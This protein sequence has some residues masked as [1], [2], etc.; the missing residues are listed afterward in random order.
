M[1]IR[2]RPTHKEKQQETAVSRQLSHEW[3]RLF[4]SE[5]GILYHKPGTRN[6]IV[7]PRKYHKR[8][9]EELHENMGHLGA[10]R[11]VELAR[12]GFYWPFMRADITHY[13]TRVCQRLTQRKPAVHVNAPL[14]PIISTAPLQLVYCS[15][16]T[17]LR[18]IPIFT[19]I[20]DHFTRFEQAYAT[21]YKSAKTAADKL[22]NDFIMR[23]R[24]PETIHDDQ[25]GEFENHL[26]YNLEKLSE[27][28]HSRTTPCHPQGNGQLKRFNRTLL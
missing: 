18:W 14:Q 1:Q 23:F 5:D 2:R 26:F 21:R 9:Y 8:V 10:D 15:S 16:R 27:V 25:G 12:E 13:V 4:L 22:F 3:K 6:Q 20:M 11:V 7:L 24:F 17:K 19:G 28:K